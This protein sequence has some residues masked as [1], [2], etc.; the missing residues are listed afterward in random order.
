MTH[1]LN[2]SK[3]NPFKNMNAN[4]ALGFALVEFVLVELFLSITIFDFWG[5]EFRTRQ[6]AYILIYLNINVIYILKYIALLLILL[7]SISIFSSI[8]NH[9]N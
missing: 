6:Q 5:W 1:H 8:V 7:K 2:A 9:R 3:W 4:E